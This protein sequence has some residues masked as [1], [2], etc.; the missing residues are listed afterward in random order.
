MISIRKPKNAIRLSR[1]ASWWGST[2]RE[3]LPTGNGI[4]GAAVYGGAGNDTIM[5]TH[6]DLWWQGQVSI[7]QDI[8]DKIVNVRKLIDE[9]NLKSAESVM[10]NALIAKGYRTQPAC[11]M[12]I[13]D[14]KINQ[15]LDRSVRDYCRTLNMENGEVSVSF[16][17]SVNKYERSVFVSRVH[18]LVCYEITKTGSKSLN[19][20]FSLELHDKFNART[21]NS[22][23]KLPDGVHT[24]Y[25]NFFMYFGA[26]SDNGLDFGV[27]AKVTFYGGTQVATDNGIAIRDADRIFVILKPYIE[28]NREKTW[29]DLKTSLIAVKLTYDKL[30]K[31]HTAIHSKLFL[32]CE[33]DLDAKDRD[34]YT[35]EL[36][37][38]AQGGD[39]QLAL[40][41][42]LWA[43]GRYLMICSTTPSSLPQAPYGIWCGDY[44]AS[45]AS[46]TIDSIQDNY[47]H[48][49]QGN[50]LEY[51][52][53]VFAYY[54]SRIDDFKK[55]ASRLYGCRGVV[56]PYIM[57]HGTGLVGSVESDVL[58]YTACGGKIA[59]LFW[60]YYLYTEDVKFLKSR[61]LPFMKDVVTFYEE[62]LKVRNID[63][64]YESSPSISPSNSQA[65]DN[66][67]MPIKVARNAVIDFAVAKDVVTN[68]IE[69]SELVGINK[70]EIPKWRDMLTRIPKYTYQDGMLSEYIGGKT[71][72][73][74]SPSTNVFYPIYPGSEAK[75]GDEL[76]KQLLQTAKKR[77]LQSINW[78]SSTTLLNYSHVFAR[79]NDANNSYE[80]FNNAVKNMT[81][82]NLM[83][84]Q[85]DWRGMGI[86]PQDTWASIN[87]QANSL[88]TSIVQEWLV[89]STKDTISIL[90]C[91]IDDMPKGSVS[92]I[93][94]RV[95]AIVDMDWDIKRGLIEVKLK[96]KKARIINLV[97]PKE[98]K[99][100]RSIGTEYIDYNTHTISSL[101]LPQS[102]QITIDMKI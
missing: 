5:I 10:Q 55:N 46:I 77:S 66:A 34:I 81:M 51:I 19:I 24:K 68:L 56:V 12:P 87:L 6:A 54:E 71:K 83:L 49:M 101:S 94:T 25:E 31:E 63:N 72:I 50:L 86:G 43:Y 61:A 15:S 39:N 100:I 98:V 90:P 65:Y 28:S 44:K 59:R 74:P 4:I 64:V 62:F 33:L 21:I 80:Q 97:F 93:L 89:Q 75:L 60:D 53:S 40:I 88:I 45:N 78:A 8:A 57:A 76:S 27:V 29:K 11:P 58:H 95:G 7:L 69:G 16:R 99:K 84:T 37:R 41:E 20:D 85:Y 48:C 96:S 13:C 2:W 18:D 67:T 26:R 52:E 38:R 91:L 36:L 47:S 82:T 23:S 32:S 30:L 3:A 14:L 79:L 35:D 17:D 9:D 102:K 1:P 92:G 42:K 73:P 22:I 70:I